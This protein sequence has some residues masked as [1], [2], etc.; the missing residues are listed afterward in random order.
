MRIW[1]RMPLEESHCKLPTSCLEGWFK[2]YQ[3]QWQCSYWSCTAK[4]ILVLA[5]SVV[6][7]TTAGSPERWRGLAS[8]VCSIRTHIYLKKTH[9]VFLGLIRPQFFWYED[10]L[11]IPDLFLCSSLV[12][13]ILPVHPQV[14]MASNQGCFKKS[15]KKSEPPT[16]RCALPHPPLQI[17]PSSGS[18]PRRGRRGSF[19]CSKQHQINPN[20][21]LWTI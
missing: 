1:S 9:P 8:W 6:S 10:G 2:H 17:A 18:R 16:C 12:S 7:F 15:W 13:I 19:K 3:Y 21:A 20:L 14:G 4:C 5:G 11:S